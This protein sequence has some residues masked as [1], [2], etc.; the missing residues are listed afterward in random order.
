MSSY[1]RT[2]GRYKILKKVIQL[3]CKQKMVWE[4][5][6]YNNFKNVQKKTAD[7]N[8]RIHHKIA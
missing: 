1:S 4:Q 2:C 7:S 8:T 6:T 3:K 5:K